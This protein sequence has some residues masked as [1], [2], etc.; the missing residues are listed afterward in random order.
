MKKFLLSAALFLV[1]LMLLLTIPVLAI[2]PLFLFLYNIKSKIQL[3]FH[4][5]YRKYIILGLFFGLLTESLAILDNLGTPPEER[6]LFH[7]DP[8][9]DLLLAAGFYFFHAL[10]WAFLFRQYT[11]TEKSIFVTG[12]IWGIIVEQNGA[13]LLSP[14]TQGIVGLIS[15]GFVFLVYG[16]YMAIP[17]LFFTESLDAERKKRTLKSVVLAFLMMAG[18]HILAGIYMVAV[19]QVVPL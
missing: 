15:Y 5:F 4:H 16:P 17:A 8:A 3:N 7:P 10:V 19:S 2:F 9:T 14:L 1:F 6:I 11:F 12:G 18:A 13:I